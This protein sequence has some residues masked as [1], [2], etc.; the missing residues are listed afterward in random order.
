MSTS[1]DVIIIG[2]GAAGLTAAQY[3]ARSN[4]SVLVIEQMASGGQALLIDELENYPGIPEAINGFEFGMNMEKQAKKFGAEFLSSTV[5]SIKK[6]GDIFT[7]ETSKES[8]TSS[9]VIFATGAK[10]REMGV[11]GE[12][13]LSGRGPRQD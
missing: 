13:E 3:S 1:K 5:K 7:I 2:G 11:K 10:H 8:F 12:K 6:D 4:L 9:A